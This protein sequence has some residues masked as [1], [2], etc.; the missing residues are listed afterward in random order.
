MKFCTLLFRNLVY[1]LI[2]DVSSSSDPECDG[3]EGLDEAVEFAIRIDESKE[4]IPLRMTF[5]DDT[6]N[7]ST[8][9]A[10]R[11]YS[12]PAFGRTEAIATEN[13]S[14]CGEKLRDANTVQFRWMQTSRWE[15]RKRRNDIWVMS[16][17]AA[18][19]TTTG[20]NSTSMT[21]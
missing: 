9:L 17:L 16:L 6:A 4:W 21:K 8:Q 3:I 18:I 20:G 2:L 1:K 15:N 10:V 14:I 19:F 7:S 11:G 12:V 13:V 5:H